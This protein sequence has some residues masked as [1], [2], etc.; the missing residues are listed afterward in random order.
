MA[1]ENSHRVRSLPFGSA[2][3]IT[4]DATEE[5][6][7]DG[8]RAL[9]IKASGPVR[10]RSRNDKGFNA[11]YPA[12]VKALAPMPDDTVIDGEVVALDPE[13]RPP[14]ICYKTTAHLARH[15][16]SSYSTCSFWAARRYGQAV[17]EAAGVARQNRRAVPLAGVFEADAWVA[18]NIRTFFSLP[19]VA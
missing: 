1:L 18:G 12:I 11:R 5:L 2:R 3:H 19:T 7:F 9:A 4:S 15:C 17:G 10:L 14:S 6:K 8:Y 16:T 13:G